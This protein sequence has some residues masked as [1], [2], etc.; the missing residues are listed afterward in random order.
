MSKTMIETQDLQ[1]QYWKSMTGID[2]DK[3]KVMASRKFSIPVVAHSKQQLQATSKCFGNITV[4]LLYDYIFCL[5]FTLHE[6]S[7]IAET[8]E[9][10]DILTMKGSIEWYHFR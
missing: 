2:C 4:L 8:V 10:R 5:N 9:D 6:S 3:Q 7:S 1:D